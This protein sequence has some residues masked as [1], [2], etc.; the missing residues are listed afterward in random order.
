MINIQNEDSEC[1]RWCLVRHLNPA[2]KNPAK[3]RNVDRE[4]AKRLNLKSMK[5]SVHKKSM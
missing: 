5:F 4:F 1:F 3:I 2:N